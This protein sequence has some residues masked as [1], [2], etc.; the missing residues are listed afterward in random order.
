MKTDLLF[1]NPFAV[2]T[3]LA[4][5]EHPQI[6]DRM[7]DVEHGFATYIE[8]KLGKEAMNAYT[9]LVNALV[10]NMGH[11]EDVITVES[12]MK[13]IS[14]AWEGLGEVRDWL[15]DQGLVIPTDKSDP[16]DAIHTKEEG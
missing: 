2:D 12:F 13:E 8:A 5:R 15:K 6:D 7:A 3:R 1:V 4:P 11:P 9:T 14:E 10:A 16:A